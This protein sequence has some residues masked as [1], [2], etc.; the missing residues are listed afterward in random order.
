M[1]ERERERERFETIHFSQTPPLTH[2]HR[3]GNFHEVSSWTHK[4]PFAVDLL[5]KLAELELHGLK[6]TGELSTPKVA[7]QRANRA[8]F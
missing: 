6:Y 4:M 5:H 8:S 2:T 3:M 7:T 1:K